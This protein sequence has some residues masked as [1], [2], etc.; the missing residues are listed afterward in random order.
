MEK[1]CGFS[2]RDVSVSTNAELMISLLQLTL[3]HFLSIS[4]DLIPNLSREDIYRPHVC[5]FVCLLSFRITVLFPTP[6][7]L[8]HYHIVNRLFN[9]TTQTE[10]LKLQFVVSGG[11]TCSCE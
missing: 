4:V 3:F 11:N 7:Q 10:M 5:L 1:S 2:V 9:S 6:L 8:S